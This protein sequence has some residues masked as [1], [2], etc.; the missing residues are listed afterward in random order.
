MST[1]MFLIAVR[2]AD[3]PTYKCTTIIPPGLTCGRQAVRVAHYGGVMFIRECE[4]H[5]LAAADAPEQVFEWAFQPRSPGLEG[6]KPDG[7]YDLECPFNCGTTFRVPLDMSEVAPDKAD[8]PKIEE[9]IKAR[10]DMHH[11]QHLQQI[12]G[13]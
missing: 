11:N 7:F 5:S 10:M 9:T 3:E 8:S 13:H 6:E 2:V 1:Q 12:R 4:E